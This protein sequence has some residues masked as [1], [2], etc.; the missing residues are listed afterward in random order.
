MVPGLPSKQVDRLQEHGCFRLRDPVD[1]MTTDEHN[2]GGG[3]AADSFASHYLRSCAL[4][5]LQYFLLKLS[6]AEGYET[7]CFRFFLGFELREPSPHF[8]TEMI[9]VRTFQ[10]GPYLLPR[11]KIKIAEPS[12][13]VLQGG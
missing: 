11:L 5:R 6:T 3:P 2:A 1:C 8:G 12:R 7:I 10:I 13:F 4:Q 9:L